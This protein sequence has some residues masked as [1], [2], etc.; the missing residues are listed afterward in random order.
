ME[1]HGIQKKEPQ[2]KTLQLNTKRKKRPTRNQQKKCQNRREP[3]KIVDGAGENKELT[4]D[5]RRKPRR[6]G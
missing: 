1:E 3:T 4:G 6:N 2:D 5:G